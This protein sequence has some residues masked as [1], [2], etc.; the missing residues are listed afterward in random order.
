MS[1]NRTRRIQQPMG[2]PPRTLT[3]KEI[4][5]HAIKG[6]RDPYDG[7]IME[8]TAWT[9]DAMA[10][11]IAEILL[12]IDHDRTLSMCEDTDTGVKHG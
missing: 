3:D 6:W 9:L 5:A 1:L 10:E 2:V 4:V 8:Q 11:N 12:S 7:G